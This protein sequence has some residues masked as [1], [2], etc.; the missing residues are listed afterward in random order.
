MEKYVSLGKPP[1]REISKSD[2]RILGL[3]AV[4]ALVDENLKI[5]IP[6]IVNVRSMVLY[7]SQSDIPDQTFIVGPPPIDTPGKIFLCAG[8]CATCLP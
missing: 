3:R 5:P 1:I 4:D 2:F 8:S 7:P 6:E